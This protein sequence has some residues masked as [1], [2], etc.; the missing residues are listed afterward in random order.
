MIQF[1]TLI[2]VF[3]ANRANVHVVRKIL[4]NLVYLQYSR[5]TLY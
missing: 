3:F 4:E 1:L 5:K 2:F